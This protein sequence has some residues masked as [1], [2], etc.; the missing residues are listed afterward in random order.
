MKSPR[1]LSLAL[2]TLAL[3]VLAHA[4]PGHDG[5][6]DF[7]WDFE[8]LANNPLATIACLAL[9]AAAGWG[10]RSFLKSRQSAKAE[11]AKRE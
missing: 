4:H 1:F 8:H 9:L 2:V 10:V 3:P 11:R 5:D 6:H 7:V